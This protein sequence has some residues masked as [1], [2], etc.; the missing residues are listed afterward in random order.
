MDHGH[1]TTSTMLINYG[2]TLMTPNV[3]SRD[4]Y[5]TKQTF[6]NFAQI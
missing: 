4:C 3:L 2:R 6:E 5:V 1:V